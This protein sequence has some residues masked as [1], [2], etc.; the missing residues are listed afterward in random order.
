MRT[1][2]ARSTNTPTN[3]RFCPAATPPLVTE[4]FKATASGHSASASA[5]DQWMGERSLLCHVRL[6]SRRSLGARFWHTVQVHVLAHDLTLSSILTRECVAS[7]HCSDDFILRD[8]LATFC[9]NVHHGHMCSGRAVR[10]R[11]ARHGL[12]YCMV[13]DAS[14]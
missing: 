1:P 6:S 3:I 9:G 12:T 10:P 13:I 7:S 4:R 2:P 5:P 14:L 8:V 11:F